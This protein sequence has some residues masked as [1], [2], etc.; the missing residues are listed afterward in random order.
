MSKDLWIGPEKENYPSQGKEAG[1]SALKC[2]LKVRPAR[3][4][5]WVS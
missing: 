4:S 3:K 5:Y 1:S 2:K